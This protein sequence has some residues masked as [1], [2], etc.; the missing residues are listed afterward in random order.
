MLFTR[1]AKLHEIIVNTFTVS[2]S[3]YMFP[4]CKRH[5][6]RPQ[7]EPLIRSLKI[8]K[9]SSIPPLKVLIVAIINDFLQRLT[10]LMDSFLRAL[11]LPKDNLNDLIPIML[12][13]I[14]HA[15]TSASKSKK[16]T[17]QQLQQCSF[18][19]PGRRTACGRE[20]PEESEKREEKPMPDRRI[21]HQVYL[22]TLLDAG[23]FQVL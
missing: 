10:A 20:Q 23:F 15:F 17:K 22:L 6:I 9:M 12:Q 21:F 3:F 19:N 7:L 4:S 1:I 14:H 11:T 16:P 2:A 18:C 5:S 13:R 8:T